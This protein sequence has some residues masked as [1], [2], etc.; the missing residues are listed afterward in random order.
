MAYEVLSPAQLPKDGDPLPEPNEEQISIVQVLNGYLS[1]ARANR[2]SGMNPRDAKWKQNLDLYWNRY[3]FRGKAAWQAKEVM[4]EVPAFV[5]RFAAALKE[6]LIASPE[7]FYTIKDPYDQEGD[8]TGALKRMTD[9][10]LST[11][12]RNQTGTLLS[13]P[14]VFEEQMKLGSIMACCSTVLWRNDVP[15]GRVCV[16]AVD[17]RHVWLDTTYRNLYRVR[18]VE[19]D[20]TDMPA[21]ATKKD[22]QGRPI[23]NIDAIKQCL[24]AAALDEK[25]Y[26]EELTGSG[27]ETTGRRAV[28]T[29]DEYIAS[30]VGADGTLLA[31]QDLMVVANEKYLIRGP[32]KNPYWH[33][34][35]WL[36]YAPLV[37]APLSVYGRSYM[38]DFGDL[39]RVFTELTNLI[40]DAVQTSAIRAYAMV[41]GMLMDPSQ[42][43]DG[44]RPNKVFWLEEGYRA[45]DFAKELQLG[46]LSADSVKVWEM[47]KNE[48]H[49][50]AKVN[51]I[52]LG[53]F[54]PKGRTSAT[55]I[56]HAAAASSAVIRAVAQ[57]V[58]DRYLNP[59]LD[60]VWKTGLQHAQLNDPRMISA[61]GQNLWPVLFE[62]RK[63]MIARPVTF[64]ARGISDMI[65][66][67]QI[68]QRLM[69]VLQIVGSN[70]ALMQAFI[71]KTDMNALL[72]LILKLSDI[73]PTKLQTSD[74]QRM[75]Q[76][77]FGPAVSR[78]NGSQAPSDMGSRA[79]GTMVDSLGVG[80]GQQGG[81]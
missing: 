74:R 64:Q 57:S 67:G 69:Q 15:N 23:F 6:A 62:R 37:N 52:G 46:N 60:L 29:L 53:Q 30:V 16:E 55:E 11:S 28:I 13:F 8:I 45:E 72:D 49:E 3:D 19:L 54:A 31:D 33:N 2:S 68:L 71:Q 35:D 25:T 1:E 40:L 80:K 47:I 77:M 59:T 50:A 81:Y 9:V 5:D 70:D 39:A 34:N 43:L 56:G 65:Q 18:R 73:D 78:A 42:M 58:E 32:E 12:G 44:I 75:M 61:V 76:E 22:S 14:A 38:E 79:V 63:E 24:E 66:R 48:L 27:A 17:P 36:V 26:R 10:W 4:P 21:M 51:E 7:G 41:P 20:I